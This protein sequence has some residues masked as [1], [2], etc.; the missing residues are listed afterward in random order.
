MADIIARTVPTPLPRPIM[1]EVVPG[2]QNLKLNWDIPVPSMA[3]IDLTWPKVGTE[4]LL[5]PFQY[6]RTKGNELMGYLFELKNQLNTGVGI[7][8]KESSFEI[9][10]FLGVIAAVVF[11]VYMAGKFIRWIFK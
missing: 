5:Q 4:W 2:S 9:V 7:Q 1:E 6:L 8:L 11:L 3:E 10:S